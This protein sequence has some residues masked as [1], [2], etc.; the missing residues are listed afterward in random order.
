MQSEGLG[1][2]VMEMGGWRMPHNY[3]H[4]EMRWSWSV[5]EFLEKKMKMNDE[6]S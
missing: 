6:V 1:S 3:S 5:A 2:D 4:K